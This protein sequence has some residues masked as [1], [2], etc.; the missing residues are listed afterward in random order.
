MYINID[1]LSIHQIDTTNMVI[2]LTFD[3]VMKWTDGRLS[4]ANLPNGTKILIP[5]K[6]A[7]QVWNPFKYI[8]NDNAF[9]GK[10]YEN[11][12][13][14]RLFVESTT[15]PLPLKSRHKYDENILNVPYFLKMLW[16]QKGLCNISNKPLEINGFMQMSP[17]RINEQL[18]Y[19]DGNICFI[20]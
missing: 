12:H 7:K 5:F 20:I 13:N 3:T 8:I 19:F 6:Q 17:E 16:N 15:P 4:Y 9:V 11:K 18:G 10:V 2:K 1:I 14:S